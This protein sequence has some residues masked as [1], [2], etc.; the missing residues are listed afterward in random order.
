[1]DP[2]EQPS[3]V[4]ARV[5]DEVERL[6]PTRELRCP[7]TARVSDGVLDAAGSEAVEPREASP[8]EDFYRRPGWK[9][10]AVLVVMV[11]DEGRPW[12]DNSVHWRWRGTRD[13]AGLKTRL[14]DLRHFFAS[15]LI[16]EGCD[17][18]TVSQALGHASTATTHKTYLHLWPKAEDKT[19]AAASA[20]A[21]QALSVR[22]T[23][24]APCTEG[25]KGTRADQLSKHAHDA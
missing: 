5:P 10:S 9:A 17:V 1:M 19:R 25:S 13:A 6:H 18:V 12:H 4:R 2:I 11:R 8:V 23:V 15:G 7:Q 22:T 20:M 14:H 3:M 21:K 16:A 24:H